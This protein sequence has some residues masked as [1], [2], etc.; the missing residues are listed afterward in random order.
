MDDSEP[1]T[2]F[3]SFLVVIFDDYGDMMNISSA[4]IDTFERSDRAECILLS[5]RLQSLTQSTNLLKRCPK[6]K[7]FT[8]FL[9][10]F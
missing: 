2:I 7:A 9:D 1:K 6:V 8:G 4:K 10:K 5:G 3:S